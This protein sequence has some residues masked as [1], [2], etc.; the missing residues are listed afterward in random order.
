MNIIKS[1]LFR[2]NYT[3][4]VFDKQPEKELKYRE[5]ISNI[6]NVF[7]QIEYLSVVEGTRDAHLMFLKPD[8]VELTR[9]RFSKYG[10]D[11]VLLN[12]EGVSEEGYGN[13]SYDYT[14]GDRFIWRSILTKPENINMWNEI[15]AAREKNIF[16]GEYL[17]G[18]ALGYP[19]CCARSFTQIW[20]KSG[21]IDTTWQQALNTVYPTKQNEDIDINGEWWNFTQTD[22]THLELSEDTPIWPS[23][24]LR[25][26]G[27]KIVPHLPCSF[28]CKHSKRIAMENMAI[29]TKY[30]YGDLYNKLYNMLDWDITWSAQYGIATIETPV[31][32][33]TTVTDITTEKYVVHKK[34]HNN[35]VL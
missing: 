6:V 28:D 23:N 20:I 2:N 27:L 8:E 3:S 4:T 12:K 15:W 26:A 17:I 21:Y 10:L 7:N 32:T 29:A 22:T 16:H 11:I 30:G 33:I 14:G 5:L 13:H 34:G 25:W 1:D 31:F 19:D 24:L 18:R 9:K 35:C